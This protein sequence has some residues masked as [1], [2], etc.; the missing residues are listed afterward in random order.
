MSARALRGEV[1]VWVAWW[2]H[3]MGGD[4]PRTHPRGRLPPPRRQVRDDVGLLDGILSY[5]EIA[6]P[7]VARLTDK[8]GL[9]G[10]APGK[11]LGS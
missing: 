6:Q 2:A 5:C 9:P 3:G 7:L 11:G 4:P 1:E 10:R 8:F